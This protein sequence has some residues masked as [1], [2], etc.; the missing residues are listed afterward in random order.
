MGLPGKLGDY[1]TNQ[2]YEALFYS[3]LDESMYNMHS[4]TIS[5]TALD[6]L[7]NTKNVKTTARAIHG[8]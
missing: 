3:L 8:N 5:T 6:L 7:F 4:M 2:L 1:G